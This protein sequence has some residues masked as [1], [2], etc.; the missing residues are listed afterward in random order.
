MANVRVLNPQKVFVQYRD[1]I[2]PY[3][4]VIDRKYTITHSD[5]TGELFVFVATNYAE[6]QVTNMHDDVKIG[7]VQAEKR[8]LLVGSV[9]IDEAGV[10][11]NTEVRNKIF[12]SEMPTALKALRQADRFLFQKYPDIDSTPVYVH[13]ISENP[14]YD[15]TYNW[16][17]IG[18]YKLQ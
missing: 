12:I 16:G 9:L 18:S 4:P 15:K 1:S 17:P 5:T 6:D 11:G 10:V 7:W 3:D 14:T 13:F 8:L 2:S